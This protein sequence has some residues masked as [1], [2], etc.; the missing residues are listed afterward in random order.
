[1]AA[2]DTEPKKRTLRLEI[3]VEVPS[4]LADPERP[5]QSPDSAL[6]ARVLEVATHRP[7]ENRI[8]MLDAFESVGITVASVGHVFVGADA[9]DSDFV[10][11]QGARW[12]M[13]GIRRIAESILSETRDRLKESGRDVPFEMRDLDSYLSDRAHE[14]CDS[15]E[16]VTYTAKAR[17]VI[18][19]ADS[20][21]AY[22]DD[23][24]DPAVSDEVRAFFAMRADVNDAIARLRDEYLPCAAEPADDETDE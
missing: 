3:E 12:Y 16:W 11:R 7:V 24:G 19:F 10:S 8:T 20:S 18:A 17:M 5:W 2:Q 9:P 14:A 6:L 13:D 1:M 23:S 22:E 4:D 21:D 15:H